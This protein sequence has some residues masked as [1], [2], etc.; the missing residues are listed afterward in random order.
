[1]TG[2]LTNKGQFKPDLPIQFP[3][4]DKPQK[5]LSFPKGSES[6]IICLILALNDWKRVSDRFGVP[7]ADEDID[8]SRDDLGFWKWVLNHPEIPIL[9]T[10]GGKKAGCLLSHGWVAIALTGVWNGQQK[11]K[12]HPALTPFIIPGRPIYLVF[13]ADVVVKQSVQDAL[14][15]LG[16]LIHKAK[17]IVRI[18]T[19]DLELGKGCDDLIVAHGVDKF[20]AAMDKGKPY[21][22][23]LKQLE[24]QFKPK[25]QR[26]GDDRDILKEIESRFSG[27][28]RLNRPTGEVELDGQPIRVDEFYITLRRRLGLKVNKQLTIDLLMQLA[29]SL[30]HI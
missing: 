24:E 9:I 11:K 4:S 22:E 26:D 3:D 2:R 7:I 12:L 23:W 29:L 17:G 14:V 5:Y 15:L 21:S 16:H 30:I 8:E 27:R 25:A 10:E 1:M 18:V 19:W 6:E 13:D 20:E 28:L